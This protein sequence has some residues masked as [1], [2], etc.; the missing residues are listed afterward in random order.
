MKKATVYMKLLAAFAAALLLL[1]GGGAWVSAQ[2]QAPAANASQASTNGAPKTKQPVP[3]EEYSGM[4]TFLAD[5]EFIQVSVGEQ[6][7]VTGFVSRFGETDSDRGE[8]LDHFF[9]EGKLEG[10]LLTVSTKVVHGI[11]YEFEGHVERGPAKDSSVEGFYVLRGVLR[12]A[13]HDASGKTTSR[14]R[15]VVFKRFPDDVTNGGTAP[16]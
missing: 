9:K 13:G 7:K 3:G 14:E 8:F 1:A 12:E 15:D 5:G 4:Y 2:S 6:G 16:H 11:S 10:D